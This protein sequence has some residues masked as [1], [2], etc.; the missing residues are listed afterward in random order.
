MC[1]HPLHR[2]NEA[3]VDKTT[4]LAKDT[5]FTKSCPL[6]F[7]IGCPHPLHRVNEADVYKTTT[8][9]KDTIFAKSYPFASGAPNPSVGLMKP[10]FT[11]RPHEL[12]IRFLEDRILWR[13]VPP[14]PSIELMKSMFTKRPHE[15]RI[16][17]L[18]DR[19]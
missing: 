8:R 2:I 18:E 6:A 15:P 13:R 1:P 4:T 19:I 10:M 16:R 7:G 9:A 14:P 12:R 17:S 3:D 5:I 11:K